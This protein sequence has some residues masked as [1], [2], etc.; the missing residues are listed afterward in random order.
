MKVR[1]ERP[2]SQLAYEVTA[3]LALELPDGQR[4]D[5][6]NWSLSGFKVPD[7]T[8]IP[9]RR[10]HLVIPF[11]GVDVRFAVT[12]EP[13]EDPSTMLFVNLKG[14]ERETLAIFYRSI[15]SG[16]MATTDDMI[17]SLDTPVD[18]VPMGETEEEKKANAPSERTKLWRVVRTVFIQAVLALAVFGYLGSLAW[19]RFAFVHLLNARVEAPIA[20]YTASVTATVDEVR[21]SV[22]DSV[23]RGDTLVVLATPEARAAIEATRNQ[24]ALTEA[25]LAETVARFSRLLAGVAPTPVPRRRPDPAAVDAAGAAAAP[26]TAEAVLAVLE[27]QGD[28]ASRET[29]GT[30]RT[31]REEAEQDRLRIASLKRQLANDKA[32]VAAANVVATAD[33]TVRDITVFEGQALSPGDVAV[34][35]EADIGRTAVGWLPENMADKVYVGQ[36]ATVRVRSGGTHQTMVGEIVD[37]SA[38]IDGARFGA[39]VAVAIPSLDVEATRAALPANAPARIA[40]RRPWAKLPSLPALPFTGSR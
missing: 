35:V 38:T 1:H 8:E 33:G 11:Q 3:P 23:A 29:A 19:D 30:L 18:L 22:G 4:M 24:I 7:G 37:V 9:P 16:R 15:L 39:E 31:L 2:M 13:A 32:A 10:G 34:T 28:A 36:E 6:R 14:R 27:T 21:V 12:L 40:A 17:T 25:Q 26:L 20:S 5:I